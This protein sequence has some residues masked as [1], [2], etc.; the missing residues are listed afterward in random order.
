MMKKFFLSMTVVAIVAAGIGAHKAYKAYNVYDNVLL[1]MNLDVLAQ[2]E[3]GDS[4]VGSAYEYPDGYAYTH[5][6]GVKI[7]N[8]W[9]SP[10]C[11]VIVINCQ[12]GGAGCNSSGCPV[13]PARPVK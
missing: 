11:K 12:G 8:N 3:S 1:K 2:N 6:C 13:H 7:S 10:R 9:F 4:E 5:E